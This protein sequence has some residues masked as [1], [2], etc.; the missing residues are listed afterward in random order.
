[1][2]RLI[3]T[4]AVVIAALSLAA[5]VSFAAGPGAGGGAPPPM[6]DEGGGGGCP[7]GQVRNDTVWK[8]VSSIDGDGYWRPWVNAYLCTS[9]GWVF[10]GGFWA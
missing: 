8:W 3:L 1:M 10:V 7:N 5:P 6:V 9:Q 4:I 2:R